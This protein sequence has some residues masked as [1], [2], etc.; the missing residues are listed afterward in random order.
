MPDSRRYHDRIARGLCPSCGS[1][2]PGPKHAVLCDP[3]QANKMATQTDRYERRRE[4]HRCLASDRDDAVPGRLFCEECL[5]AA[6]A[7]AA[8]RKSNDQSY[9]G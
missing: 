7:R 5:A 2:A 9:A 1:S 8:E 6:R 4:K 3:C